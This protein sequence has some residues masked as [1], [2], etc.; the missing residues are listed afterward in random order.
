MDV[1]TKCSTQNIS[2][3]SQQISNGRK[4]QSIRPLSDYRVCMKRRPHR[5]DL[6]ISS[7]LSVWLDKITNRISFARIKIA[8]DQFRVKNRPYLKLNFRLGL[9]SNRSWSKAPEVSYGLFFF[10]FCAIY[11]WVGT[12]LLVFSKFQFKLRIGPT[13]CR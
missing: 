9:F 10:F 3:P 13:L 1:A 12:T 11:E 5:S 6:Q 2:T 4:A 7:Q 8:S